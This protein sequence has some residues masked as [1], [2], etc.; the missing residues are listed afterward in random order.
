MTTPG[1]IWYEDPQ[2]PLLAAAILGRHE[3][4]EAEADISSALR[5]FLIATGLVKRDE[6]VEE[7]PPATTARRYAVDLTVLDT[8]IEVKRRIGAAGRGGPNPEYVA[9][10]DSYLAEAE[11]RGGR[12][13]MGIL[14][15]GKYWLLR[16]PGAGPVNTAPP[17]GF[18]LESSEQ[19]IPLFEWLRDTALEARAD[20]PIKPEEV[21]RYFGPGSPNYH[22]EINALKTRY[23]EAAGR[24]TVR[25]KRRL[26]HDLL[27]TALGEIAHSPE[28]LDDLFLRHTYLSAVIGMVVQASFGIDLRQLADNEP[29]DLLYGRRFRNDTG[30]QGMVESDFFTWP[31]ETGGGPWLQALARRVANFNWQEAPANIGAILYEKVIPANERRQL[32][33]YYTPG[34]LAGAMARELIT[35]PLNQR[36]LDP[37]CGS[38]A[39][40]TEAVT[41]FIAAA[42]QTDWEPGAALNRLREAVTG[43]DV[44]PAAAHLARAAWT[45]AARPAINAAR[46]AGQSAALSIPVYL[47]DALQLRFRAGDLF[48][49]QEITIQTQDAENTE[50]VFPA[51]LVERPEQFDA[52]MVDIAAYIEQGADPLLALD[53]H[54][55]AGVKERKTLAATIAAMQKLHR[56]GRNHIWAYYTRNMVRPVALARSKVDVV[57][58]NPPWIN[59]NQTAN[60]LRVELEQLS[61]ER[62]GIWAGGHYATHQDVAG[63]FFA[64]CVDLYL[65]EGG[66]IG[67]VMPHS[68]LQAGQF[69]K[70][71]EGRWASKPNGRG[72]NHS[73]DFTLSV[74]FSHKPAW[75][76]AR[77]EPNDFFPVAAC[78]VFARSAGSGG[79][80]K[81][82]A[83]KAE[84]WQG[85]AGAADIQ[86]VRRAIADTA[87]GRDSHYEG[88]SRQGASIVPRCLF[89]V[90][91][92]ENTAIIR[93]GQTITVNPRRGV[94]DK[95]PWKNLDLTALG[96]QTIENRHWFAVHLG[97]TIAPYV[98]LEPLRALLPLKRGDYALPTDREGVGGIRLGGLERRM[99]ERWQIVSRLWEDNKRPVNKLNLLEQLDYKRKLSSQLSW[100]EAPGDRPV[101]VVYTSAGE[102]TAALLESNDAIVESKLFW[103]AC[104]DRE[105]ANYLLAIINSNALYTAVQPLMTTGQY[106]ARDLQKHLW[107][108]PIPEFDPRQKLHMVIAKA[109]ER[110]AAGAAQKLAEVRER[111][112]GQASVTII[113]RE[114]R[115]WLRSAAEGKE[116]EAAVAALLG[117]GVDY[118]GT[119]TIEEGKRFGKPCIRGIRMTAQDVMEYLAGGETWASMLYHFPNLVEQDLYVCLSFAA[120]EQMDDD[121]SR[122]R[123]AVI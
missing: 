85:S 12:A 46:E 1:H 87:S 74:K 96:R 70:W 14:T 76:L 59:Y 56:Q 48:A 27:R 89:F 77:L 82:L 55:I 53:D 107:Q 100:Q 111:R 8:F 62:Y 19:W 122:L 117:Q 114:L 41:H 54:H 68:A 34:W 95:E 91:E 73:A 99:R 9:Q 90:N 29:E 25:V 11:K 97:E 61:K 66:V 83:G 40:I 93:A 60:V 18:A 39:F 21:E 110:A 22:R 31:A 38:G 43:I 109:G 79:G 78:V 103:I 105:E 50:L 30:L 44:H 7:H 17:Y 63:L 24:E 32:G 71:R 6:I 84:L 80:A 37:A 26:W 36:V 81:S 13:R 123:Y 75:D 86:R 112:G 45:L 49:E 16:W 52:L 57:I 104:K 118:R 5:D 69:R 65:K 72:R 115:A 51:S 15:D 98:A 92:T 3:R 58:G 102:P 94:Y 116:V 121:Y 42:A 28:Q 10:L 108:L 101:R 2:Y 47:G 119:I 4:G 88:Y 106:G 120:A 23:Q 33:E 113:R 20:L 35:D 67:F 64:R